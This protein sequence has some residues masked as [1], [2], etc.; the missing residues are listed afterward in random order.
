[1]SKE[2]LLDFIYRYLYPRNCSYCCFCKDAQYMTIQNRVSCSRTTCFQ[3]TITQSQTFTW[4]RTHSTLAMQQSKSNNQLLS[5][6]SSIQTPSGEK[7]ATS[8]KVVSHS[9]SFHSP[10]P[11]KNASPK[12]PIVLMG[13]LVISDPE[14]PSFL[15][16]YCAFKHIAKVNLL[17]FMD[18]GFHM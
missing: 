8:N 18:C 17:E 7:M 5:W 16:Q 14:W 9:K 10:S 11:T 13:C 2:Y 1:M 15:W 4:N 12:M 3:L 6:P